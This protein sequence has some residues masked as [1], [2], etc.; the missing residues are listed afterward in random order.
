MESKQWLENDLP[1][2]CCPASLLPQRR[3]QCPLPA[4]GA[5]L[6][7][8]HPRAAAGEQRPLLT[9][10]GTRSPGGLPCPLGGPG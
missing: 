6:V 5:R 9:S 7:P 2:L 1:A 4:G 3:S 10:A 8:A